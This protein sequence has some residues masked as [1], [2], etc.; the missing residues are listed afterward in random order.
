M[1]LISGVFVQD[2]IIGASLYI[3]PSFSC[4]P[5]GNELPTPALKE[6]KQFTRNTKASVLFVKTVFLL[7]ITF[8]PPPIYGLMQLYHLFFRLFVHYLSFPFLPLTK[9]LEKFQHIISRRTKDNS[10]QPV[11]W[12]MGFIL[13]QWRWTLALCAEGKGSEQRKGKQRNTDNITY[14]D[15]EHGYSVNWYW[16]K[17]KEEVVYWLPHKDQDHT[18]QQRQMFP[19]WTKNNM[20]IRWHKDSTKT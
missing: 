1:H 17:T 16:Q 19:T 5:W 4:G 6:I 11:R 9:C 15:A 8:F 10:V 18:R 2:Q 12:H 7:G 13:R 3:S 20:L 14:A